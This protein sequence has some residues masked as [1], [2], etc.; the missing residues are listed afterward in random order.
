MAGEG[1]RSDS[2]G[3]PMRSPHAIAARY[4]GLATLICTLITALSAPMASWAEPV[5]SARTHG[6]ELRIGGRIL[7]G[8]STSIR[9]SSATDQTLTAYVGNQPVTLRA[10]RIPSRAL[11]AGPVDLTVRATAA[12]GSVSER[13]IPLIVDHQPPRL[14]LPDWRTTSTSIDAT[15]VDVGPAGVMHAT[16]SLR[17]LSLGLNT[18]SVKLADRAGNTKTVR[19][20]VRREISFSMPE[21]NRGSVRTL[22]YPATRAELDRIFRFRQ[23]YY[24]WYWSTTHGNPIVRELQRRLRDHGYYSSRLPINGLMDIETI[25]AVKRLQREYGVDAIATVGPRTR[26][27]LDQ[28]VS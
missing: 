22:G 4:V 3:F 21:L 10:G 19:V 17:S 20:K 1:V 18:R 5:V 16:V 14:I 28:L 8:R 9:V 7:V 23:P 11:P 15:V 26:L 27:A 25:K 24:P 2:Y 13:L 6:A 12:D